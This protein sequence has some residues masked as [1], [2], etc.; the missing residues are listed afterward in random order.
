[1]QLDASQILELLYLM[2][3]SWKWNTGNEF[4]SFDKRNLELYNNGIDF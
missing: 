4:I 1:M 2:T 3:P